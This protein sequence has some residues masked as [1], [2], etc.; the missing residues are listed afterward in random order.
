MGSYAQKIGLVLSG[1]GAK[2]AAHVGVLKALDENQIPID[3]ITGTSFGAIV[4]AMY[5]SGYTPAQM[6]QKLKSDQFLS[7]AYGLIEEADKFYYKKGDPNPSWFRFRLE[8]DLNPLKT[9]FPSSIVENHQ[10]N[11]R[12]LELFAQS[13]AIAGNDFDSLM[14]PFRCVATDVYKS[15]P[16]MLRSGDLAS[17]IRASI[18][19]P[20]VFKPITI[21][22][23]LYMD[24]GMKNNF[25]VDIMIQEFDPDIIIGS[26]VAFNSEVPD[27]DDILSQIENIFSEHTSFEL[28]DT[29]LLIQPNVKDF[30]ASDFDRVDTLIA[31]G[32]AS[33][34]KNIEIIKGKIQ[35]RRSKSELAQMRKSYTDKM[36]DL[37]FKNVRISGLK[38]RQE[39]YVIKQIKANQET[40]T[41]DEFVDE[42][43]KLL[44]DDK[45][46]EIYPRAIYDR[47][48]GYFDL[49]LNVKADYKLEIQLGGQINTT[50]KNFAY[51]G[52][53]YKRFGKRG[54]DLL[55]SLY[56]GKMY[57]SLRV[58]GTI[59]FPYLRN[60]KGRR[61]FPFFM[62]ANVT[63]SR[64][65]YFNSTKEWFFEDATPSYITR[66]E[67]YFQYNLGL[68]ITTNG[69]FAIGTTA[70]ATADNYYQ[71]NL[72][73][74]EDEPEL[75]RFDYLSPHAKFEFST[76]NNKQFESRGAFV[77]LMYRN[78]AGIEHYFPGTTAQN[79]GLFEEKHN[80][81]YN[82]IE[83]E[84]RNYHRIIDQ[85][86]LGARAQVM[87]TEKKF[88]S[89]YISTQLAS[90]EFEPFPYTILFYLPN[91]RSYS[92]ASLG[93]MPVID[94]ADN[95]TFR[96]E[97]HV[98]QPYKSIISEL[99]E[100]RYEKKFINR[101]FLANS[102][103]VYQ[104]FM[105]P[106]YLSFSYLDRENNPW[107]LHFGFGF[108]ILND[109]GLD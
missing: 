108:L 107:F 53:R 30:D 46:K 4:G 95:L 98:Y 71:T 29:S 50:S 109:R 21:D 92:Y 52:A 103:I 48:T 104:T 17:A 40:F 41:Y 1:G 54:Y 56:Y 26:K 94:I 16:A 99:Y 22:G 86:Y 82:E 39:Q 100:A 102:S 35:K 33:A 66:R 3:Y 64:R 84:V 51:I 28:P 2:G 25:P 83:I 81:K 12:L 10:M 89:N 65:D 75:T 74:R 23:V 106:I 19:F 80:H 7:W 61:L 36:P 88:F 31:L 79:T 63:Y 24:G 18:T 68:P 62:D 14:V 105:G 11:I 38:K 58:K 57:S 101:Y 34:L 90:D 20:L 77:K 13:S 43:F 78:V 27:P 8:K 60:K 76:L 69:F 67:T 73:S 47:N 85:F 55:G 15:K 97:A 59:D 70:G 49:Y 6:E 93:I 32:Y 72:I 9:I 42:Y 37:V 5:A 45:I 87:Y 44:S 96:M 91:F